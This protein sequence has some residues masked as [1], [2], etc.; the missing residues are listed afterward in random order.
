MKTDGGAAFP[1]PV[2]I[3]ED[4]E[5]WRI[6]ES[7]TGMTLRDWYAGQFLSGFVSDQENL[8]IAL[9]AANKDIETMMKGISKISFDY[10]EFMLREK[11]TRTTRGGD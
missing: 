10:A 6:V 4:Y 2:S 11:N 8:R 7:Q 5:Q 1:R 3:K 9:G